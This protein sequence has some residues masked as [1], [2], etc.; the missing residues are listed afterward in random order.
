MSLLES[1]ETLAN[2]SDPSRHIH[3]VLQPQAKDII[4]AFESNNKRA[5]QQKLSSVTCFA[6]ETMVTT[7]S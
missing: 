7:I 2:T 4:A 5:I 3:D 6:H 1:I